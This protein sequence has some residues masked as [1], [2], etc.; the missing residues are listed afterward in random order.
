MKF[1]YILT[2]LLATLTV[3]SP[4]PNPDSADVAVAELDVRASQGGRGGGH[5]GHGGHGGKGGHDPKPEI[6]ESDAYKRAKKAM[7]FYE[8]LENGKY[9]WFTQTWKRGAFHGDGES[10]QDLKEIR[11]ELGFDHIALVS[12]YVVDKTVRSGKKQVTKRDFIGDMFD[13]VMDEGDKAESSVEKWLPKAE[14]SSTTV[15]HG[16]KTSKSKHDS[17]R[18]KGK[19]YVKVHPKYNAK[20][21]NCNDYVN[22][23]K[24]H[25]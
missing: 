21:N 25:V 12:G 6:Q 4:I 2:A 8:S 15:H 16:G 10:N 5:S 14:G 22:D 7:P 20:T 18:R 17:L 24:K 11:D 9:Y 3:A 13:L 19:D 1:S 23:L